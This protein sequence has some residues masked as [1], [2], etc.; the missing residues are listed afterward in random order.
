MSGSG[1]GSAPDVPKRE[2]SWRKPGSVIESGGLTRFESCDDLQAY[3]R[4]ETATS[5]TAFGYGAPV[6]MDGFGTIAHRTADTTYWNVERR[7]DE[8]PV[9]RHI[10]SGARNIRLVT[11]S[12]SNYLVSMVDDL[13]RVVDISGGSAEPAGILRLDEAFERVGLQ[14]VMLHGDRLLV[15]FMGGLDLLSLDP[16]APEVDPHRDS[17]NRE[18]L[19]TN[20][21]VVEIGLS[22]TELRVLRELRLRG[23][24]VDAEITAEGSLRLV[25]GYE[26]RRLPGE[27]HPGD[28]GMSEQESLEHNQELARA[29]P[30]DAWMP[31]FR[32]TDGDGSVLAS[33]MLGDCSRAFRLGEFAGPGVLSISTLEAADAGMEPPI[34]VVSVVASSASVN[35]SPD[36]IFVSTSPFAYELG[37]TDVRSVPTDDPH[38]DIHRFVT[39]E[40]G[41]PQYTDS[42]GITGWTGVGHVVDDSMRVLYS[43][44]EHPDYTYSANLGI[45][46]F[47]ITDD[48]LTFRQSAEV[49]EGSRGLTSISHTSGAVVLSGFPPGDEDAHAYVVRLSDPTGQVSVSKSVEIHDIWAGFVPIGGDMLLH[50][51]DEAGA[52][53]DN[54]RR[55]VLLLD[56]ADPAN[57][58]V[59]DQTAG[60]F[61]IKHHWSAHATEDGAVVV[62][63]LEP[64][65]RSNC[66]AA[67]LTADKD[68]LTQRGSV[69]HAAVASEL[70]GNVLYTITP[71]D[72]IATDLD[73]MEQVARLPWWTELFGR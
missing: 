46:V 55:T 51:G 53:V 7:S 33:G 12:S 5:V 67:I 19:R 30:L 56:V 23:S 21:V 1:D 57:P 64:C 18:D 25:T 63:P 22:G 52:M 73:T 20:T 66:T 35:A 2:F 50:V 61:A 17:Y 72:M 62:V 11:A 68:G 58:R 49:L 27:T 31:E 39:T 16:A 32:L 44:Y 10:A 13:I 6:D 26:Q 60:G 3:L 28:A 36:D 54:P 42:V 14:R 41:V 40:H 15:V 47:D 43:W 65:D 45:V 38:A 69:T 4:H 48:G 9:V 71:T 34:D 37:A 59:A 29:L 24:F 8:W 70:V